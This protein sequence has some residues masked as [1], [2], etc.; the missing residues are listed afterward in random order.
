MESRTSERPGWGGSIIGVAL[1][2]SLAPVANVAAEPARG[3]QVALPAVIQ[4]SQIDPGTTSPA[5]I[6]AEQLRRHLP[7][8]EL[9]RQFLLD[10]LAQA[11]TAGNKNTAKRVARVLEL[12]ESVRR[13]KQ[14]RLSLEDAIRRTLANNFTIQTFSYNPAI[15]T[16]RVIE[17]E[18]A[19]DTV[20]FADFNHNNVDQP[21]DNTLV[22]NDARFF[23]TNFGLRKLLA[24]GAQVRGQYNFSRSERD[25][26]FSLINPA[27][28]STFTMEVRQP[29]LRGF[30]LDF[31]RS[32]IVAANNNRRISDLAFRR[33][34]RDTLRLVEEHY[35]RLVQSRRKAVATARLLAEFEVILEILE[36]RQNFDVRKAQLD[37]TRASL[38]RNRALL[39]Q[40]KTG[41]HRGIGQPQAS[42]ISTSQDELVAIM[43]D[44]E[45]NL[46]DDFEII[47]V[48]FPTFRHLT[49]DRVGE[50]QTALDNRPEIKEQELRIANAKIGVGRA[51]NAELPG[52]TL[53]FRTQSRGLGASADQSFDEVSRSNFIDY[54][55]G[56][57]FEVAIGNR[58]PR[59]ARR[60][61]QLQRA[62]GIAQLKNTFEDIILDVN[63]S[64]DALNT[65]YEQLGPLSRSMEAKEGEASSRSHRATGFDYITLINLLSAWQDLRGGR[66]D[67]L[68]R[69]V[70]YNIAIIDLERAKGTLLSYHG[71]VIP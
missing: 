28:S 67:L 53:L 20:M 6:S 42:G 41:I 46:L 27:Y 13:P 34:I 35:W 49:L 39:I 3:A 16:T 17:A 37:T 23:T 52:L 4:T 61:A 70:D 26:A 24:T 50:L 12:I 29:L 21:T 19:F 25:L 48:D 15:E 22:S 36:A 7:D 33:T 47:P 71:V 10:Q 40:E 43:N 69:I 11:R 58:G 60:R 8:P 66:L 18:A 2:A 54:V 1:V 65:T 55:V 45:L 38:E 63:H 64:I 14:V 30:G 68:Q 56:V 31:N 59:A 62:Q 5:P 32:L 57:E 51:E 9:D 44:P